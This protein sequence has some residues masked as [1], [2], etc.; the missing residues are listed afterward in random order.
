MRTGRFICLLSAASLAGLAAFA[1]LGVAAQDG[2]REQVMLVLDASGSMWGQIDGVSKIEIAREQIA[3][4]LGTWE[5]G[6]DLGLISYGH[7][8]RGACGDIEI[9]QPPAPLDAGAFTTAVNGLSP[10]GMTPLSD[11]VR[12]AAETMR[13]SEQKATVILLSDGLENCNADPCAL[14]AELEASGIDFTAH[15]IGFDIAEAEA[16]ELS[17]L[18]ETTGGAFFLAG[19]ADTLT[20]SLRQTVEAIVEAEPEPEPVPVV[21]EP[22]PEPEPEGPTGLR[23][24]V[25]LCATCDV[26]ER[27]VLWWLEEPEQAP[28]GSRKEITRDG[29]A[30]V[31]FEID[32]GAY[33]LRVRVGDVMG[34]V[35]VTVEPG[36][37]SDILVTLNAGNLRV[38]AEA[39]PGGTRLEDTMFYWVYAPEV[40]LN[41]ERKEISRSGLASETFTLA[42]G[43]YHVVAR[44]GDA[45]AS[46]DVE[47]SAGALTDI[48][49][50]MNVG[51]LRVASIPTEGGATLTDNQFYWIYEQQADLQGNRAEVSR[52]GSAE[53][54]FRLPAGDYALVGR[55]GEAFAEQDVSVSADALTEVV[56]DMNVGYLRVTSVMAEGL[57]AIDSGA[58]YWI[59]APTPD[60]SGNR[61]QIA[62]N[63]SAEALFRLEAG[64]Y[65][66]VARHGESFVTTDVT[67]TAGALQELTVV[68]NSAVLRAQ[69]VTQDGGAPLDGGLFWWILEADANLS[70]ERAQVTANGSAQPVMVVKAG[71]YLLRA[72]YND[73]FYDFP[74]T[75]APGEIQDLTVTLSP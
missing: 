23:A 68:Q 53:A 59:N 74:V 6:I 65:Q 22:E 21:V 12:L 75:L 14:A 44:H 4:M 26:L 13:Y 20:A 25:Q 71:D 41:G 62:A 50:D 67:V 47:V 38:H 61:D 34:G 63:G 52:S 3:D 37:L 45:F 9:V 30:V 18:A 19:S 5:P 33:F 8:E 17:C 60:L 28:D 40:D 35:P 11:S 55:H 54:L 46:Q 39:S 57:P 1:P 69:A 36:Q 24:R 49:M 73:A 58:F 27:D 2:D 70:G 15:V 66:L 16:A 31:E 29:R 42:E 32:P 43:R 72:R 56:L 48:T 7:R 51:Y 64:A 10:L